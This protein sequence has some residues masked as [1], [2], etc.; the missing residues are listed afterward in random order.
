V[1]LQLQL[2]VLD[3]MRDALDHNHLV[4]D[5]LEQD[6]LLFKGDD[7]LGLL[8]IVC[9]FCIANTRFLINNHF[10]FNDSKIEALWRY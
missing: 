7:F 4:G 3:E 8:L 1:V 10:I 2:L 6:F 5:V 9:R